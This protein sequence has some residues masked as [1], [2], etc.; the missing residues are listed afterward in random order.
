MEG[1]QE[2]CATLNTGFSFDLL[3]LCTCLGPLVHWLSTESVVCRREHF[4]SRLLGRPVE[5][6]RPLPVVPFDLG[7]FVLPEPFTS[8]ALDESHIWVFR[9]GAIHRVRHG[10]QGHPHH[11]EQRDDFFVVGEVLEQPAKDHGVLPCLVGSSGARGRSLVAC[12]EVQCVAKRSCGGGVR[13]DGLALWKA[14][15]ATRQ[16][17]STHHPGSIPPLTQGRSRSEREDAPDCSRR[18]SRKRSSARNVHRDG[19]GGKVLA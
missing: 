2:G 15:V 4:R 7:L 16:V 13:H 19:K 5:E 14:H 9:C 8:L 11:A 6:R 10:R 1:K 12:L 3:H 18:R 17:E